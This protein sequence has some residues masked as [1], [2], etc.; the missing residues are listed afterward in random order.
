M[1]LPTA[2]AFLVALRRLPD[3]HH[4]TDRSTR[5][6]S[7]GNPGSR[8]NTA[9]TTLIHPSHRDRAA[10]GSLTFLTANQMPQNTPPMT[11]LVSGPDRATRNSTPG[12]SGSLVILETP[13][14]MNR[15]I[16]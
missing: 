9:S 10:T 6:P 5:P 13:P 12:S 1:A 15:V 11:R 16:E 2:E 4:R 7:R 8:L 14:N 3:L